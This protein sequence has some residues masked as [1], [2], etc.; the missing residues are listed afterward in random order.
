MSVQEFDASRAW[1]RGPDDFPRLRVEG[2]GTPLSQAG[3]DPEVELLVAERGGQ[4]HAFV[5]REMA[6]PHVAQGDLAGEPY[7]V[8]F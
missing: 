4:R 5:M 7:L 1:L 8:A 3:L 6:H 2:P